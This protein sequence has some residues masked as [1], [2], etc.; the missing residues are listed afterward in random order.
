MPIEFLNLFT[1]GALAAIFAYLYWDERKQRQAA[2]AR[3][4]Q[5]IDRLYS[6]RI[7]DLQFIAKLPTD[8]DGNY[9]LGPDSAVKA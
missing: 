5:D 3:H 8:L 7:R 1:Q 4:E 2:E 9:R 6:L